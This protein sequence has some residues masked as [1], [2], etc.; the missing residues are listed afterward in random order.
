M[1]RD[2]F[3]Q[4]LYSDFGVHNLRTVSK[5]S[6]N[7]KTPIFTYARLDELSRMAVIVFKVDLCFDHGLGHDNGV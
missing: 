2:A 1:G 4:L 7:S 6:S 3:T 5:M